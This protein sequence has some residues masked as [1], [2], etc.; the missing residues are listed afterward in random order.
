MSATQEMGTAR[1]AAETLVWSRGLLDPA[2]REVVAELPPVMRRI[3]AYHFGWR[4][5]EDRPARG[6][7]GK[8][9]R[10]ALTLLCAEAVGGTAADALPA[11][12]AVELAHNFSLLHDDVMDGDLTRR[13]RATAWSV[14]GANAAILAG[15][16]LLAAAF[17]VVAAAPGPAARGAVGVLSRAMLELVEGQS[18]DM[19]FEE[20]ADVA[21]AEC[22]AMA[23]GKTAAL[24]GASCALGGMF[25][26]ATRERVE[27][28]RAFGEGLGLAFQLVDDLLGVWG[29]PAVTGK[30]VY[31]DL[32]NRKKSLPVV[33][34]L[35]S[36]TDAGREL[37]TLYLAKE[38]LG[39]AEL[40]RAARLVEDAGGRAWA[41]RRADE[42]MT[43][44]LA[45]L[46][47][48]APEPPAHRE[49]DAVARLVTRRD[50]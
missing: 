15:D 40:A 22:L 1:S 37:R 8:A 46:A 20:R 16:A 32:R 39:D 13:H 7:A 4:D 45:E 35:A 24:M 44:A 5:E 26:G 11:A 2:L 48:A 30:P 18:A 34:A 10:P 36:G 12:V 43:G 9:I 27:R 25:G 50:H 47:M 19:A 6:G 3:A 28:L 38:P 33:A 42:L 21:L 41:S 14:F 29:D 23:S 49:L 17:E 31:S